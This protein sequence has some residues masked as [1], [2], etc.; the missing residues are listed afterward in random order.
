LEEEELL[1]WLAPKVARYKLP[2]RVVFLEELPRSGYGKV[3]KK[4]VRAEI[5]RRGYVPA[6]PGT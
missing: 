5:E 6:S 1:A 2:R 4:L 3:T